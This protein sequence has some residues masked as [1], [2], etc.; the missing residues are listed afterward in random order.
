MEPSSSNSG[1]KFVWSEHILCSHDWATGSCPNCFCTGSFV[2]HSGSE[3][4]PP[5]VRME[6]S[7]TELG[8]IAPTAFVLVPL[9]HIV[10]VKTDCPQ[11]GWNP[12]TLVLSSFGQTHPLVAT[13]LLRAAAP[14]AFVLVPLYHIAE[15]KTDRPQWGWYPPTLVL[16]QNWAWGCCPNCS[17][18]KRLTYV[19]KYTTAD[20]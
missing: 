17:N 16:S 11:W 5:S 19:V 7:N 13:T 15:V 20:H 10:E 1:I 18:C 8:A 6:P 14:T 3:T 12:P 4:W 2:P 9:Y